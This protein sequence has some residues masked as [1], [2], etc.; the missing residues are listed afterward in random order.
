MNNLLQTSWHRCWSGLNATGDGSVLMQRL[1]AAHEEPQRKYHTVQHLGECLALL[2]Q[3]LD[4]AVDAAEVGMALWFH[5]AIYNV[6]ASD[7]EAKSAQWAASELTAAGVAPE[8]IA[9]IEQHILA[10]RHAAL[11]EGTDQQLL[12]DI[13]LAILGAPRPRFEEYERQ[14]RAE[15]GWVPE[16]L[17]RRTRRGILREFLARD[18]IY[19]THRFRETRE[20]QARDNLA[21]SLAQLGI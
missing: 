15:Y 17:F 12:V 4:L 6:R 10:T 20:A 5:D 14:V 2:E 18:P 8:R 9:H 19:N 11:A 7:N 21:W 1:V 13:D 3:N 16:F